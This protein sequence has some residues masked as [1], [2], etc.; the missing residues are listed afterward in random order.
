MDKSMEN[1]RE[2]L[3]LTPPRPGV[4]GEINDAILAAALAEVEEWEKTVGILRAVNFTGDEK[5]ASLEARA[6][7][8]EAERDEAIRREGHMRNLHD[9]RVRDL[10]QA[11]AAAAHMLSLEQDRLDEERSKARNAMAARDELQRELEAAAKAWFEGGW[12]SSLDAV[13]G[14][15]RKEGDDD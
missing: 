1:V 6:E 13:L 2:A 9:W 12:S 10:D 4:L 8:A 5:I 7:A 11:R 15:Y 14:P 3:K